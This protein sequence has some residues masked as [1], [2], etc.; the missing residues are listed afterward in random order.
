MLDLKLGA[1]AC[2][3]GAHRT[4]FET[5]GSL[6]EACSDEVVGRDSF[7]DAPAAIPASARRS[8]LSGS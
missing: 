1:G 7:V 3:E 5:S 8:D 2:G 4:Y 6:N